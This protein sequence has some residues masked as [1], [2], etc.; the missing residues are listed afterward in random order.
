MYVQ[1]ATVQLMAIQAFGFEN[2]QQSVHQ[3]VRFDGMIST[4]VADVDI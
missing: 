2:G 4:E 1:F 3:T